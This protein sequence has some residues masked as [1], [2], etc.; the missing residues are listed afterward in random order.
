VQKT[1]T[2]TYNPKLKF[3]GKEREGYSG[4]DYFGARYFNHR[5]YRFNSVDPIINRVAALSNPQLW[6][7]YA[8]SRNNPITYFDPDGRRETIGD[9][10]NKARDRILRQY[11]PQAAAEFE[12]GY[13]TGM[14][15]SIA[16]A[17][18]VAIPFIENEHCHS[19]PKKTKT[20]DDLIDSRD[21]HTTQGRSKMYDMEGGFKQA[22]KDFDS[23]NPSDV[24]SYG[25]GKRVGTLKDGRT[26]IVRRGSKEGRPT[27]EIQKGKNKIKFRYN[28]K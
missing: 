12:A 15:I 18:A 11:G 7:L 24:Q 23:L 26:V 8:Y 19:K 5:S 6:N 17:A 21:P 1:W 2:N 20:V 9:S 13:K 22:N 27:L 28:D 3:S 4:L 14:G 16:A 10:Y 25:D